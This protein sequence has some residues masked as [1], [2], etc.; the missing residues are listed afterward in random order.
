[1]KILVADDNK[2]VHGIIADM[3]VDHE[4]SFVTTGREL[5]NLMSS[6]QDMYDVL[7]VDVYMPEC[8]GEEAV[9]LG[10][11]FGSKVPVVFMTGMVDEGVDENTLHKPFT[12]EQLMKAI[13][14]AIELRKKGSGS[15]IP[16]KKS[17]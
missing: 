14:R 10:R 3:M 7:V 4:V 12:R 15:F 2:L 1:M 11:A 5:H 6:C 16:V 13:T 8:D 17:I 9:A